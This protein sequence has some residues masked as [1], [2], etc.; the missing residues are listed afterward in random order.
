MNVS[1]AWLQAL[2]PGLDEAPEALA[3]RLAHRGAPVETV[4]VLAE[5]LEDVVVARV[6]ATEPHTNADR[7]TMCLVDSGSGALLSVVCGAPNVRVGG[8]Y[9]FARVGTILPGDLTIKK[10]KIRGEFSEGMLC[11][12]QE[13]GLGHDQAG[14]LELPAGVTPGASVVDV[15]SLRD[16]RFD[17]EVTS[18]RGD[19]LSHLGIAREV[20]PGGHA[21]LRLP[22]ALRSASRILIFAS[23]TWARS[24]A[25]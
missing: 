8:L 18:N 1:Y 24:C 19:L 21:S 23:G 14:L 25:A 13:L 11:S 16:H 9:P 7:L 4:T 17:V 3:H 5:G 20:A 6:E 10:A 12:A 15:L 22:G 2:A